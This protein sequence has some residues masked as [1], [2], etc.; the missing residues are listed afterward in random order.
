M[1]LRIC[2]I[3]AGPGQIAAQRA[4]VN[5]HLLRHIRHGLPPGQTPGRIQRRVIYKKRALIWGN[6]PHQHIGQGGF[7]RP[8]WARHHRYAAHRQIKCHI[9]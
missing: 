8:R 1:H 3:G 2:G 6:Q 5:H 9:I 4:G 7:A